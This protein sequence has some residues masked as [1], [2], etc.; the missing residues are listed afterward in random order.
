MAA[1]TYVKRNLKNPYSYAEK[2]TNYIQFKY[3][4][5]GTAFNMVHSKQI[6]WERAKKGDYERWL[7]LKNLKDEN[8]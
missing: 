1:Y 2:D 3:V 8:E 5:L 4:T 7:Q 6:G